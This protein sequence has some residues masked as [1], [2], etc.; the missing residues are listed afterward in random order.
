[1]ATPFKSVDDY[2]ETLPEAVHVTIERVRNSI[3]NALPDADESISYNMP[4][5]K[6]RGNRILYFAVW[7]KHYALYGA[8]KGVL[9]A[10]QKEL[11][12]YEIEKGTIRFPLSEPV[13]GNLIANIARF[14]ATEI[15]ERAGAKKR[16]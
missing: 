1:M 8:T 14:R 7:K 16:H 13:P 6:M 2:I 10:F 12:P 15:A 5:Y 11:A 3:R 9:E 4:T